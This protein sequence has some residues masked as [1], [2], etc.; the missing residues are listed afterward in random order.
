M[1]FADV[2]LISDSRNC[3]KSKGEVQ[4]ARLLDRNCI[5]YQYE[6]PL[7]VI[8]NGRT[9]IWYPDFQLP[10]Y[11]MIIEYFGVN[12]KQNYDEQAKH[13]MEVY[14]QNGIEGLFLT[15]TSFKG[16]WPG[17][18]MNQIEGILRGRVE[19]FYDRARRR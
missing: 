15:E 4:I 18:I 8:D 10:G 9:R 19:R 12:G 1:G 17:R 3:F 16:D 7:A 6:H 13:K 11:G 14:R 5:G 2:K